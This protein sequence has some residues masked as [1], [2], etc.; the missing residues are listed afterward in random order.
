M[1]LLLF[2]T[3]WYSSLVDREIVKY[4]REPYSSLSQAEKD[5]FVSEI[6][7]LASNHPFQQSTQVNYLFDLIVRDPNYN[8][9]AASVGNIGLAKFPLDYGTLDRVALIQERL[10]RWDEALKIRNT[11]LEIDPRHPRVRAYLAQD[12]IKIGKTSEAKYNIELATKW[13]LAF[14]DQG[15]LKYLEELQ[16]LLK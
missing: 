14:S 11:Q 15:T 16:E 10:G 2:A 7:S 9:I 4:F 6:F 8:I 5:R 13:A 12:L 1:T 3:T